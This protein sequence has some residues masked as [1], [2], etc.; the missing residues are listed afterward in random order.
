MQSGNLYVYGVSNPIHYVDQDG[1]VGILASIA[2]GAVV[3]ALISGSAQIIKNVVAGEAW[4]DGLGRAMLAGA[5]S[6][7]I[8]VLPIPGVGP[9]ATVAITGAAGNL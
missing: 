8:S 2:I 6:G 7:A 4:T 3:G 9:W 5:A 1:N